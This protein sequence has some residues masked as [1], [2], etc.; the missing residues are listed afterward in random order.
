M[1]IL[2]V[3]VLLSFLITITQEA[4]AK[5]AFINTGAAN[6][7]RP[8]KSKQSRFRGGKIYELNSDKKKL[9]FTLIADLKTPAKE[10]NIFTS[11]YLDTEKNEIMTEEAS[12]DHLNLQKYVIQQKQLNEIYEMEISE[13]K[14]LFSVT[15][16]GQT[17]KK[18]RELPFN[19]IIGPSFAPFL[20]LHW[21]ELQEKLKVQAQLAV[22]EMMDTF[23]F[24]FEKLRDESSN[25]K[26][27]VVVRMKP[28][29]TLVSAVVRPVYFVLNKDGSRILEL[30]GRMLPKIKVG[31]H[32]KDLE[33][34][35]VFI[36]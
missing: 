1:K 14:I 13:D 30:K 11:S 3:I 7:G 12:F 22:P 19:L 10:I 35:A 21:E 18:T 5:V 2:T 15:K 32:W 4:T 31:T 26:P 29:N 9:L 8:N 28:H 20:Q 23:G 17:E 25:G 34:E 16:N 33:A 27:V 6:S 36:F 24:E